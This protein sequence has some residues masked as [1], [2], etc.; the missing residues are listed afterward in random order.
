MKMQL[1]NLYVPELRSKKEWLTADSI[2][3]TSL[4]FIFL[5]VFAFVFM[6][7]DLKSYEEKIVFLEQ[8]KTG[9]EARVKYIKEMPRPVDSRQIDK[10]LTA[11][12]KSIHSREQI[13]SIIEGQNL[14]NESGFSDHMIGFARQSMPTLS[15]NRIRVSR[16]G[17]FIELKGVTTSAEDVPSFIENLQS[18][19]SFSA[20]QF[21]LMSVVNDPRTSFH[22][23][24]LGFDSVFLASE[25][26][27]R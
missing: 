9:I 5:I 20:S 27:E 25:E 16:G 7:R 11:L 19:T 3:L 12:K 24:A 10:T 13:G 15:L 6:K 2:A 23:F 4:G 18:E 21:G 17:S 22:E 8:Q 1:V 14:G 26:E